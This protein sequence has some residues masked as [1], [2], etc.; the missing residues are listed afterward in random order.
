MG[1]SLAISPLAIFTISKALAIRGLFSAIF[2]ENSLNNYAFMIFGMVYL[3]LPFMIIP[4]YQILKDMPKN[5]IEASQDLGYSKFKTALKVIIPYCYKGILSGFGIILMMS[6][7]SIIISDKLLPNGSQ[8]QLIGNLINQFANTVNPFDLASASTL[9]I[10][11]MVLLLSL[12]GLIY[13]IPYLISKYKQ[14]GSYE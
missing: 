1:L 7:T 6:S 3:Y 8:K 13:G 11:T 14:G 5:I 10:I 9:V 12:Y 4:I 2:D